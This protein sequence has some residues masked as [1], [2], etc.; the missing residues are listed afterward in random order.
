MIEETNALDG[1]PGIVYEN[2]VLAL[3]GGSVTVSLE[4]TNVAHIKL[5][6]GKTVRHMGCRFANISNSAEAVIQ[7]FIMKLE[8]D[9][10]ARMT[11]FR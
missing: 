3:P 11:G 1:K 10:N 9:Q 5:A 7:R 8:R 2:C 6:N 4:I